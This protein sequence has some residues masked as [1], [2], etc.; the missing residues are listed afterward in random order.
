MKKVLTKT[1]TVMVIIFFS[2]VM[3]FG[4]SYNKVPTPT[5]NPGGDNEVKI[6]EPELG[7]LL[8]DEL[9]TTNRGTQ[10]ENPRV[11]DDKEW[12]SLLD[13]TIPL[14]TGAKYVDTFDGDYFTSKLSPV[15]DGDSFVEI[16]DEEEKSIDGKSLY[17]ETN[18]INS[19]VDF[20]GMKF[21]PMATYR[22]TFDYNIVGMS[23]FYALFRAKTDTS[24]NGDIFYTFGTTLGS[25]TFACDFTLG[26]YK[27]YFFKI[28]ARDSSSKIIIDNLSI[29]RLDSQPFSTKLALVG[30]IA[31][32]STVT[33]E[34]D[35]FDYEND[36]ADVPE[37]SWFSAL[38]SEGV[39]KVKL[40]NE[41]ETL[42][43]TQDLV[44]R[45]V[46]FQV[47]AKALNSTN[48]IGSPQLCM[49]DMPVDKEPNVPK[50]FLLEIGESYVEE[51]DDSLDK[52]RQLLCWEMGI[53]NNYMYTNN[54]NNVLKL[55]TASTFAGVEFSGIKF[56]RDGSYK[57]SFDYKFNSIPD[58]MYVQMRSSIDDIFYTAST[59][60]EVGE[61]LSFSK[62]FSLS[63]VDDYYLQIF[64]GATVMDVEIDNLMIERLENFVQEFN[65]NFNSETDVSVY[66]TD[67]EGGQLSYTE[68]LPN[69]GDGSALL[70]KATKQYSGICFE[71]NAKK[72][73]LYYVS[74]NIRVLKNIGTMFIKVGETSIPLYAPTGYNG[75]CGANIKMTDNV[76]LI[77]S[78][79]FDHEFIID[80]FK[81]VEVAGYGDTD[82]SFNSKT[83]AT[84]LADGETFIDDIDGV[85]QSSY[86][87]DS[88]ALT[89]TSKE[90][91]AI[92][93]RSLVFE[94]NVVYG[95]FY[96]LNSVAFETGKTY[97]L[98]FDYRI[99]DLGDTFYVKFF[100]GGSEL[101]F[102]SIETKG[103]VCR[104]KF[105]FTVQDLTS[106]NAPL[107][108]IMKGGTNNYNKIII[109]NIKI[110]YAKP[111]Y[112]LNGKQT[113]TSLNK[114]E[115]YLDDIEDVA[116]INYGIDGATIT[117]IEDEQSIV[118]KSIKFTS[119][120]AYGK[121]Y[122][123][124]TVNFIVGKTYTIEFDYKVLKNG[125]TFYFTFYDGG[126]EVEFGGDVGINQVAR[127]TYTFTVG[128][129]V[130]VNAPFFRLM[131]GN[132]NNQSDIVI[133]NFKILL[134]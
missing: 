54:S 86:D 70:I 33:A 13:K 117:V 71:M 55:S 79:S 96:I 131:K 77:F 87:V 128:Q 108:R 48:N 24:Y 30:E 91:E 73:S 120:S 59:D 72:N 61:V 18:I 36:V 67:S 60:C 98:E 41:G 105:V 19:G 17:M 113:L 4:C 38:T 111:V 14:L 99:V 114:G 51:F 66:F 45:Y 3:V 42:T 39:N 15:S 121:V 28:F 11:P 2:L 56:A 125:D 90:G 82:Y 104:L 103:Q 31:V 101:Q 47:R 133:D 92:N 94:S 29:E 23:G 81:C 43:I 9:A 127:F 7:E 134:N 20:I 49:S 12:S 62:V 132:T 116:K 46:G 119:S 52:E 57:I 93:N 10:S 110:S 85:A 126:N 78:D 50:E 22:V 26:N 118:G 84:I 27:D 53:T 112:E 44:G 65:E 129:T 68:T 6:I 122:L 21:M 74:F 76:L 109:D 35:Y 89:F 107:I 69:G 100:D 64:N 83:Q 130:T 58:I 115:T 1:L 75:L 8:D 88:G 80:N 34:Y 16:T 124:N 37:I 25:N 40:N 5:P 123:L 106:P 95:K 32:G 102:G 97:S 63:N